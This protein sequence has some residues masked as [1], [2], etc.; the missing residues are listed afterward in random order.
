MKTDEELLILAAK[1]AGIVGDMTEYRNRI[2]TQSDPE[3]VYWS[4]LDYDGDALRLAVDLNMDVCLNP[5]DK[6]V[7]VF[8]C[9]NGD[10][11]SPSEPYGTDKYA[12]HAAQLYALQLPLGRI[13]NE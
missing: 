11:A 2:L 13:C 8:T 5:R 1:A 4:P 3:Y 7:N 6:E 9:A 12:A 10:I